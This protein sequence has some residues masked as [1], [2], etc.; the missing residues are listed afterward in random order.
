MVKKD[1]QG[2]ELLD[3][4]DE[5][6][7]EQLKRIISRLPELEK[8]V[9]SLAELVDSGAL[10]TIVNLIYMVH[11]SKRIVSD[12][13]VSGTANIANNLLD[14]SS[15]LTM[16]TMKKLISAVLDHQIE[17]EEEIKNTKITG[18]WSLMK[19]LKDKDV[20]RGLSVVIA[21]LKVLGR[22]TIEKEG[23]KEI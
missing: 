21:I 22:Y 4:L 7:K 12:E 13:M 9:E 11:L 6:K 23:E 3:K 2:L 17:I 18:F 10:E 5:E 16:P 19:A 20:Q 8:A 15:K 1:S 14:I